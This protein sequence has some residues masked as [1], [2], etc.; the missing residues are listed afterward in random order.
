MRK[1]LMS[2][3]GE[4]ECS[5]KNDYSR[6]AAV[7][8]LAKVFDKKSQKDQVVILTENHSMKVPNKT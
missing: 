2:Q 7:K 3:R 5:V 1:I 4:F 6:S 8:M